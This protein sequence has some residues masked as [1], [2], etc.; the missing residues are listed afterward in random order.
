M[1]HKAQRHDPLKNLVGFLVG[2]VHY[3]L[4][5]ACVREIANPLEVVELPRAANSV[6]GVAEY[7]GDVVP[8]VELRVRFGLPEAPNTRRTKWILIDVGGRAVALVVDGVTEVF[9]TEGG[10]LRA[11]PTLGGGEDVRGISGVTN[12]GGKL[13]FVLET[14]HFAT[15]TAPLLASGSIGPR[16]RALP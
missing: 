9:G 8:V 12:F 2:D 15:L 6:V 4:P 11:P 16:A 10:D 1:Q 7:R 13:V 5:I 14:A 3:A